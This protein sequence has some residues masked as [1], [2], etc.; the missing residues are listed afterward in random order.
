[1]YCARLWDIVHQVW[2]CSTCPY[3]NCSVL[4]LIRYITLWLW[5]LTRWPWKFVV[6][7]ASRDQR[8]S[9]I[10]KSSAESLIISRFL[11]HVMSRC[12]L[13]LW[14]LD[15]ELLRHFDCRVFKLCTKFERNQ[16]I[17]GGIID[18]LAYTFTPYP[19]FFWEEGWG[20]SVQPFS[21]AWTQ[22]Q[23]TRWGHGAI[24]PTQEFCYRVQISCCIFKRGRLKVEWCWKRYQISHFLI[25]CEN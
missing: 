17:H 23:Q 24:I 21:G 25:A 22:L 19:T 14:P 5:P 3:L 6:Y 2:P 1:M 13:D 15:P 7:Y 10:E 12:D 18:D 16:I 4:M 20:I 9:D 11:A 8:L